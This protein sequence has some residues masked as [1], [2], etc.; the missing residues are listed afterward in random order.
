MSRR[1]AAAGSRRAGDR[2]IVR[3]A[4]FLEATGLVLGSTGNISVRDSGEDA[5]RITPTRLPYNK[6]RRRHLVTVDLAGGTPRQGVPSREWPLHAAIYR[7]RRDVRAIVHTHSLYATAWSFLG[8]PMVP[9][10]EDLVY[11]DIGPIHTT[12]PAR[13]GSAE[14][15]TLAAAGLDT[16]SAVLL[17]HHGVVTVG[18]TVEQALLVAQIVERQ[19]HTAWLTGRSHHQPSPELRRRPQR[20]A[21]RVGRD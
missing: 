1:D 14:L 20:G 18:A 13:A 19:A 16:G 4:R 7:A 6:L 17:G 21:H 3:G 8:R 9:L 12:T 2:S 5:M 15:G 11:Y 10:L